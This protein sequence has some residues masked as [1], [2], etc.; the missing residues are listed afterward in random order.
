MGGRPPSNWLTPMLSKGRTTWQADQQPISMTYSVIRSKTCQPL[1]V[2]CKSYRPSSCPKVA[3]HK[4]HDPSTTDGA[5]WNGWNGG[6]Q[7][8]KQEPLTLCRGK[9]PGRHENPWHFPLQIYFWHCEFVLPP[10]PLRHEWLLG[11]TVVSAQATMSSSLHCKIFIL[12]SHQRP[13]RHV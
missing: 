4:T 8:A 7:R 3:A 9:Q 5:K 6:N 2:L 11:A 13:L 1:F 12:Y 10:S